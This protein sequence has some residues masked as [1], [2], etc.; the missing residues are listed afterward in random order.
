MTYISAKNLLLKILDE[1]KPQAE[2]LNKLRDFFDMGQKEIFLYYPLC[3]TVFYDESDEKALP[4]NCFRVI[5]VKTEHGST[6]FLIENGKIVC[7]EN[8]FTLQYAAFPESLPENP[9]DDFVFQLCDEAIMALVLFVAAQLNNN[10]DSQGVYQS[11]W[12]QY[13][14]KLQNLCAAPN[15]GCAFVRGGGDI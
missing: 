15:C 9:K 5:D 10:D 3:K 2:T 6:S 1:T 14:N 13:Q 7:R 4:Q 11:Y 12:A 8:S